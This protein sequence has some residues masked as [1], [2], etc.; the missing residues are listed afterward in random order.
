MLLLVMVLRHSKRN[1][2]Q[3]NVQDPSL[4]ILSLPFIYIITCSVANTGNSLLV[5]SSRISISNP[6]HLPSCL[7]S[8]AQ[9]YSSAMR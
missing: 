3:N 7:I 2:K 4:M 9:Q 8:D 6:H 1:L 5:L